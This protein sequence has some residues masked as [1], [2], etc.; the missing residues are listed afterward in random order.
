MKGGGVTGLE[1]LIAFT[2]VQSL[3]YWIITFKDY[4]S[5]SVFNNNFLRIIK[6]YKTKVKIHP[7]IVLYT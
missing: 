4:K 6:F 3:G 1:E 5:H 2:N 7:C